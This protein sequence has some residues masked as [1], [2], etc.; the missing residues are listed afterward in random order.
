VRRH[1][2]ADVV[3]LVHRRIC[4]CR[5]PVLAVVVVALVA[6]RRAGPL[7]AATNMLDGMAAIASRQ[8]ARAAK[9][10]TTFRSCLRCADLRR[11]R[12]QRSRTPYLVIGTFAVFTAHVGTLGRARASI[13]FGGVMSKPWR[14]VVPH[15]GAWC[16][17]GRPRRRHR[18][19][20]CRHRRLRP[21][22]R[23]SAAPIRCVTRESGRSCVMNAARPFVDRTITTWDGARSPT[24]LAPGRRRA[25]HCA[26]QGHEHL[27]L[28]ARRRRA[29]AG[30]C[31]HLRGRAG[32]R[33]I[34]RRA[35][36]PGA[37]PTW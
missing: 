35:V 10:S 30:R 12:P 26:A 31:G 1:I 22:D 7:P 11:R 24:A 34:V 3:V 29:G 5:I 37:W 23:G 19:T 17:R 4:D 16:A 14:M 18:L 28:A 21:D 8:A 13:D 15:A 32:S 20:A 36:P 33:P 25:G 6:D 27:P 2:H 9:S